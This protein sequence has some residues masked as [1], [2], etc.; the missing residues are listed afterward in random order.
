MKLLK[1]TILA[2]AMLTGVALTAFAAG[3]CPAQGA[4]KP[5]EQ[6]KEKCATCEQGKGQCSPEA[7]KQK[8]ASGECKQDPAK[9]PM[10]GKK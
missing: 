4:C 6:C 2:A 8:Q 10:K 9:C 7:C 3:N 5:G 1:T